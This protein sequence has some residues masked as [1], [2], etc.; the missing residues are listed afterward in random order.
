MKKT[1]IV[2]LSLNRL[3][4]ERSPFSSLFHLLGLTP[5]GQA[6]RP[7]PPRPSAS[8]HIPQIGKP[9]T[10]SN[11]GQ[12]IVAA[13]PSYLFPRDGVAHPRRGRRSTNATVGVGARPDEAVSVSPRKISIAEQVWIA[14]MKR[15]GEW[16]GEW[17][18]PAG[19]CESRLVAE[20]VIAAGAL[21]RGEPALASMSRVPDT[22]SIAE[23]V[24]IAGMKCRGEWRGEWW[25]P[26]GDRESRLVAEKVIAAGALR[27]GEPALASMSRAP[28]ILSIAEQVR[29]AGMTR[30]GEWRP[31]WCA[32]ECGSA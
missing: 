5:S 26:A 32:V 11:G 31:A 19:D 1:R 29:I 10:G 27:R 7:R 21:R 30:R 17:W 28:E 20:K 16:R 13:V 15:R 25:D 8:D 14:G 9:G 6:V 22:L 4:A 12:H 2:P 18:D 3:S 24:R 23:Q